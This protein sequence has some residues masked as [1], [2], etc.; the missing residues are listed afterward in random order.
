MPLCKICNVEKSLSEF[1]IRDREKQ[2]P[3]TY[4][5][6]CNKQK[7]KAW[8]KTEVGSKQWKAYDKK[9]TASNTQ[10]L[11]SQRALGC[12]KCG[13]TRHYLID[14]HHINPADKEFTIGATNRWTMT[15]LTEE[16]TKCC[17]LCAN[18]HREFH[19]KER[20]ENITIKEYISIK[21]KLCL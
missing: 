9:R 3:T 19:Y 8:R 17:R 10:W 20:V 14:F 7:V 11:N 18:C 13:D 4:C 6:Q 1:Y 2:T 16:L 15:Q 5:K 12:E 21:N